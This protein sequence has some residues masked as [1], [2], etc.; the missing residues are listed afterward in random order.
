MIGLT[1]RV[2]S[3][4]YKYI[5]YFFLSFFFFFEKSERKKKRNL[6]SCKVTIQSR[7][8]QWVEDGEDVLKYE[9]SICDA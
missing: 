2:I 8:L 7:Y 9:S 3:S 1:T 6:I 5:M 4:S